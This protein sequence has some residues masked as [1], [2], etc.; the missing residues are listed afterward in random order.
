[1]ATAFL[2]SYGKK[3]RAGNEKTAQIPVCLLAAAA[4]DFLLH[5][6]LRHICV[7]GA[8]SRFRPNA[9]VFRLDRDCFKFPQE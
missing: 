8:F 4:A 6:F 2:N 5:L 1:M 7:R 3:T 9:A